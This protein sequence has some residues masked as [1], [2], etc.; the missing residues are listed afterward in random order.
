MAATKTPTSRHPGQQHGLSGK[1]SVTTKHL[2]TRPFAN[3]AKGELT[4]KE[5]SPSRAPVA[6]SSQVRSASAGR[7]APITT[8]NKGPM[9]SGE[10]KVNRNLSQAKKTPWT[11]EAASRVASASDRQHGDGEVKKDSFAAAAMSAAMKN[12]HKLKGA[13]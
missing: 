1:P 2:E 7:R 11:I 13:K 5:P 12:E 8:E 9:N 3:T 6:K 10:I 4:V